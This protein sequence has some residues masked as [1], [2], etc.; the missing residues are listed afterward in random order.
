MKSFDEFLAQQQAAAAPDPRLPIGFL[1]YP[2]R[3]EARAA[4]HGGDHTTPMGPN[5]MGE[6]MWPLPE[7]T[8]YDPE[9][10]T[11]RIGFS[12]IPHPELQTGAPS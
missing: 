2:G 9:T 11:T 6:W 7:H 10:D 8:S 5:H 12:L 3:V 4:S 1:N